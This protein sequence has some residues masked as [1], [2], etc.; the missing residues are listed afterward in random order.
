MGKHN[1]TGRG[2]VL[3]ASTI[4]APMSLDIHDFAVYK[5]PRLRHPKWIAN[6]CLTWS[7][8]ELQPLSLCRTLSP[9]P[10]TKTKANP[11]KPEKLVQT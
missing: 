1:E 8:K 5:D 4:Q 7:L 2:N 3:L 11:S 6:L 10:S 9:I